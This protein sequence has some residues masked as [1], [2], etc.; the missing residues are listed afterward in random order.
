M[1]VISRSHNDGH[2]YIGIIF[3]CIG[4]SQWRLYK[5]QSILI[6]CSTL[7]QE[8]CKPI[9]FFW[10][11]MRRQLW[12]L[13]CRICS[14]Y[15]RIYYSKLCQSTPKKK[16]NSLIYCNAYHVDPRRAK[17]FVEFQFTTRLTTAYMYS[18]IL[19]ACSLNISKLSKIIV[20]L[21]RH[22][23]RNAWRLRY[24]TESWNSSLF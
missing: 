12:T 22:T 23:L 24:A 20:V 3:L 14:H 18:E 16:S 13:T 10:K 1:I 5:T 8:Y 2:V 9:G 11:L 21:D 15:L 17:S 19:S 7:S 4:N 6:G